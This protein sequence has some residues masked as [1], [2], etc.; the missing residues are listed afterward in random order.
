MDLCAGLALLYGDQEYSSRMFVAMMAEDDQEMEHLS[1][2]II[3]AIVGRGT[4]LP[5]FIEEKYLKLWGSNDEKDE[6][7]RPR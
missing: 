5:N 2:V 1:A 4:V 7:L 3:S 6:N